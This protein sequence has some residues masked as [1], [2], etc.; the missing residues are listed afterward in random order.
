MARQY[1]IDIGINDEPEDVVRKCNMNFRLLSKSASQASSANIRNANMD[2]TQSIAE[3]REDL[4]STEDRLR[5]DM[6]T[7]DQNLREELLESDAALALDI[8][9]QLGQISQ[10]IADLTAKVE[11][12][13]QAIEELRSQ[14]APAP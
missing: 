6:E 3:I 11:A 7:A 4:L 8:R 1:L 14:I 13:S 2:M 9:S 10:A 5:S 12:N